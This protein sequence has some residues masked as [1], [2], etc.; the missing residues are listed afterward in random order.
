MSS[1]TTSQQSKTQLW[2]RIFAHSSGHPGRSNYQ[3]SVFFLHQEC[4]PMLILS[5][6]TTFEIAESGV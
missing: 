5:C 3:H 2:T 4:L 6:S 1:A